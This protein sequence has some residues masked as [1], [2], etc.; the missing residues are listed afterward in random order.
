[1]VCQSMPSLGR[2]PTTFAAGD[3]RMLSFYPSPHIL[4]S[5]HCVCVGCVA[6]SNSAQSLPGTQTRPLID[7]EQLC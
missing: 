4:L 3:S 2:G 1:V 6:H 7:K 5:P